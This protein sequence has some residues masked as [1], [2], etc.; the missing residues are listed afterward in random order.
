MCCETDALSGHIQIQA[1]L[2]YE[3]HSAALL[4][5][6][7]EFA[8]LIL[9]RF[10]KIMSTVDFLYRFSPVTSNNRIE[11][12]GRTNVFDFNFDEAES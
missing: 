5:T 12:N 7:S 9:K 6:L 8:N 3:F 10:S 2:C 11:P 4:T 1:A